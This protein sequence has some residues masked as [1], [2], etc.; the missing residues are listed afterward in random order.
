MTRRH[1]LVFL[2]LLS[3]RDG[4][5]AVVAGEP[6]PPAHVRR[7]VETARQPDLC[8]TVVDACAEGAAA[9]ATAEDA[10]R[11]RLELVVWTETVSVLGCVDRGKAAIRQAEA[12]V[13]RN[14]EI[15]RR[16]NE[17]EAR[18]AMKRAEVLREFVEM[19]EGGRPTVD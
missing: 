7:R 11:V 12:L 15:T 19:V 1:L 4:G 8:R 17:S 16:L 18:K 13:K 3:C 14:L 5:P 10:L 9:C 2:A 6:E